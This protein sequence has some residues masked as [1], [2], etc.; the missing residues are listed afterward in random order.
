MTAEKKTT[1]KKKR[2]TLKAQ[3]NDKR[4][5]ESGSITRKRKNA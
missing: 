2:L 3:R 5:M 4:T 1:A